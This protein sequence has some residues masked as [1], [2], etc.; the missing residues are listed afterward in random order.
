MQDDKVIAKINNERVECSVCGG[1]LMIKV[2]GIA[3]KTRDAE[4][5]ILGEIK[6]KRHDKGKVCNT[7]NVI[8]Y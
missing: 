5:K 2:M 3:S 7:L 1:L 6:C 4:I 8:Q